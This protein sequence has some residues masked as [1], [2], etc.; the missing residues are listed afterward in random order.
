MSSTEFFQIDPINAAKVQF[1]DGQGAESNPF[2]KDTVHYVAFKYEMK[3]LL[4]AKKE[5]DSE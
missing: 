5:S 2:D 4:M 1:A 3:L